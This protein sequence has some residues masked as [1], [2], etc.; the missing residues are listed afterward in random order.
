MPAN[1]LV[2]CTSVFPL[3]VRTLPWSLLGTEVSHTVSEVSYKANGF[4]VPYEI[5]QLKESS[6]EVIT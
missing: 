4:L 1:F 3:H 6:I 2:F 5:T